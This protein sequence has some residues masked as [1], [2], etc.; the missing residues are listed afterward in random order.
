MQGVQPN[1]KAKP[2]I[3]GK[4]IFFDFFASNLFSKFRYGILITPINW[5][6]K[7]TII[8]PANNLNILWA[9]PFNIFVPFFIIKRSSSRFLNNY[10][11]LSGI[12]TF[13][14]LFLWVINPKLFNDSLMIFIFSI[15][16]RSSTNVIHYFRLKN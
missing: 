13:L 16:L 1:P 11:M 10:M 2:I 4:K 12:M 14:I 3:Y 15:F 9:F 8:I 6:E 5:N 7:I